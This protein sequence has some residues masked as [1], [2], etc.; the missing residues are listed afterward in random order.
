[1]NTAAPPNACEARVA[2][3]YMEWQVQEQSVA[4]CV[5][6]VL[7]TVTVGRA[8]KQVMLQTMLALSSSHYDYI[9]FYCSILP[10]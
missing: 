6:N 4:W 9:L 2:W 3:I 8:P 10:I 5:Y 1:M 7:L